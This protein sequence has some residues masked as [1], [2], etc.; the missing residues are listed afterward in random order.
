[1]FSKHYMCYE[2]TSCE[3]IVLVRV[4]LIGHEFQR[5]IYIYIYVCSTVY[6]DMH[7]ISYI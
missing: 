1:M 2:V 3:K 6:I 4:D 5:Y 7:Y